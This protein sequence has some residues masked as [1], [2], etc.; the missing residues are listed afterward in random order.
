[1]MN[2]TFGHPLLDERG[3]PV[4]EENGEMIIEH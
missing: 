4:V 1:M 3:N 2:L